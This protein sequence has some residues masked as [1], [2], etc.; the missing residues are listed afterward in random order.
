MKTDIEIAQAAEMLPIGQVA[1]K[2]GIGEELLEYYGR[3]KA[4]I[5]ITPLRDKARKGGD[6]DFSLIAPI[7]F[8]QFLADPRL[9]GHLANWK[10][11]RGLG[12][13]DVSLHLP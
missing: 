7:V 12:D 4:K 13:L 11:L 10:H 1:R 2:A 9:V 5:D 8:Q 6:V 3:Y